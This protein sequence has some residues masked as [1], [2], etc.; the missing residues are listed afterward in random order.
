M[1]ENEK[2]LDA[3]YQKVAQ[4]FKID[5]GD[6]VQSIVVPKFKGIPDCAK[7]LDQ[8]S[9][10]LSGCEL[11]YKEDDGFFAVYIEG[12]CDFSGLG[13]N[14]KSICSFF[15]ELTEEEIK[16]FFSLLPEKDDFWGWF[17]RMEKIGSSYEPIRFDFTIGDFILHLIDPDY[18]ETV[19]I[20]YNGDEICELER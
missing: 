2:D 8:L 15:D 11:T 6:D 17:Y 10:V 1:S 9:D 16:I 18:K 5:G 19:N 14:L 13:Y 20:I 12:S 3:I 4:T 7:R